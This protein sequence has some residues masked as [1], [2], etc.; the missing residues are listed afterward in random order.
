MKPTRFRWTIIAMLFLIMMV[1]YIDRSAISFAMPSIQQELGLNETHV[2]LILGAFGLGYAVATFLGGIAVDRFGVRIVLMVSIALWAL[3]IG[4]TGFAA[5]FVMLYIAR[6]VLGVAEG[7]SF[8]AMGGAVAAWLPQQERVR[9]L[10]AALIAVPLA[11]AI[12]APVTSELIGTLGWRGT[13]VVLAV[14]SLLWLPAWWLLFRDSPAEQ[15]RVNQAERELIESGRG[16]PPA[17]HRWPHAA[18]WRMLLS[19][20]TLLANYWAFFVF[21]YFLFFFMIWMPS[22]LKQVYQLDLAQ[23]GLFSILPWLAA[24]LGMWLVGRFSDGLHRRGGTLRA[25]RSMPIIVTQ[26]IAVLAV[27]PLAFTS[28]LGIAIGC[29]TLA[30]G[31]S[32]AANASYF[33]VDVAPTR[34]A[35]ALG[36]MDAA[37]AIAGFAAPTLTGWALGLR[38]SYQDTFLLMA[39]LALSSVIVMLLFH[40]PDR[41]REIAPE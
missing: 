23:I 15:P 8:P 4:V 9:A 28:D 2:G 5:G 21:G 18:D 26:L 41:D 33:A 37:F 36:V 40:R 16:A 38:H 22:Y 39:L 34:S 7:P 31:A 10:S 12:G 25:S 24:A 19:N 20:R 11:L 17:S 13:F 6:M 35:T 29:I 27:A 30:V 1:N 32:M 14:L 3:S